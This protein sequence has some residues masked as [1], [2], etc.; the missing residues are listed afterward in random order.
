MASLSTARPMGSGTILPGSEGDLAA[1]AAALVGADATLTGAERA[2]ASTRLSVSP[3]RLNLVRHAIARDEDPLGDA[4]CRLRSPK[5]RRQSGAVY[6]PG[7]IIEAMIDWAAGKGTPTRVVD[8]GAGSGRFLVAAGKA[9]PD[10]ELIGIEIDPLAALTLRANAS[11]LHMDDRLTLLVDDYRAIELPEID[12]ATLFLG[13]PPYVRHHAI[14]PRWKEWF[15]ATAAAHGCKASKLAGLHIHFLLKTRLLAKHGDFGAFITSA[16]WLD[17]NYGAVL[18]RLLINGLGGTALHVIAPAAMPFGD[19]ATTGAIICFDVGHRQNAIRFRSVEKVADLGSLASGQ[20]VPWS[21]LEGAHRW[22]PLLRPRTA[23]PRNYMELGELCRVHRGQVTGCNAV[24]IAGAQA[25]ALPKSALIPTVTK[26]RELF[27]AVPILSRFERLRRVIDLPV[28]LDEFDEGE[29]RNIARF[30][31]W[32]KTLGA[33]KSYV[34]RHRR[35]WWAVGLR[36]PA[37]LLCT[38]M[39]R[40]PPAFVR[41]VCGARHVNIA[42]GIY[43]RDPLP[44]STLDALS[45]WLRHEVDVTA[46]R[47]Y[48][49][50]LTKFEP[51]ELERVLIPPL[52]E[53]HERA[54]D[55]DFRRTDARFG[56][57]QRTVPAS[58]AR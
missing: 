2:I 17:V 36:E 19:T 21:R 3:E 33:D 44:D 1:I 56:D 24:W 48:A 34:A 23:P 32:A 30:L 38:Y 55:L 8:P 58:S 26:A 43:P 18:R 40:R 22:S 53:L 9:F 52:E 4:F 16:E 50:G 57:S 51:K 47:T 41:N 7:A 54:Q 49:G 37:P 27:D 42:H 15:A 14:S 11:V 45:A 25:G 46:G 13:N 35:A 5:Y 6:T 31:A 10:A 12:G 20:N 28:S 39:A 29:R